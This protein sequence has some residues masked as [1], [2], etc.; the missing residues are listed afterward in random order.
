MQSEIEKNDEQIDNNNGSLKFIALINNY[1]ESFI[2]EIIRI[3][4][5]VLLLGGTICLFFII[6]TIFSEP[7]NNNLPDA[8][9][10]RIFILIFSIGFTPMIT[11]AIL[12]NKANSK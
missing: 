9:Y 3:I 7:I 10:F 12:I 11:G 6:K 5:L 1:L 2:S 4:G 8:Y